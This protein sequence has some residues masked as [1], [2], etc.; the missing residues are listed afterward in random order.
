MNITIIGAGKVGGT[1]SK[2]FAEVGHR[3][4][5][6]VRN[7]EDDKVKELISENI[8]VHP[9]SEAVEKGDVI[10]VAT[11]AHAGTEVAKSLGD[12]SGK[13]VIDATNSVFG[14]P[15][16]YNTNAEAIIDLGNTT[17]VVKCF[18]CTGFDNMAN[19]RYGD[20]KADMFIAGDSQNGKEVATQLA[21]EIG[22]GE[23]YDLGGN[24]KF[25]LTE[26]LAAVWVDLARSGYG[27]DIAFKILKRA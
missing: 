3:V 16:G 7:P 4:F 14:K 22:F 21:K 24:D 19:P 23:V 9:V 25:E 10:L 17:D 12:L 20:E 15:E 18:N 8:T 26:Q 27:R 2:R 5:L 13:V 6:G 1:L 11:P